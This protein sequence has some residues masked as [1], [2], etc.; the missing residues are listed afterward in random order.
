[1]I[2]ARA[3]RTRMY[4]AGVYRRLA[5]LQ[6]AKFRSPG[7]IPDAS[8][9]AVDPDPRRLNFM[10]LL[11]NG[12]KRATHRNMLAA[13]PGRRHDPPETKGEMA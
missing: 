8:D 6:T 1:M 3:G 7:P 2:L 10:N 9:R 12:H 13:C 11:R 4:D 5:R